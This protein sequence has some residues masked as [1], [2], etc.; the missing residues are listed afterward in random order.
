MKMPYIILLIQV[1]KV[2]L[3]VGNGVSQVGTFVSFR[4]AR[5]GS[6]RLSHFSE[7]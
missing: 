6:D 1:T 4:I 2:I 3:P 7:P 5:K